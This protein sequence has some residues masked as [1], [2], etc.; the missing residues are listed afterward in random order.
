[1]LQKLYEWISDQEIEA[2]HGPNNFKNYMKC[3]GLGALNGLLEFFMGFGIFMYVLL[4]V[5]GIKSKL[6]KN[7]IQKD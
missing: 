3:F 4:L 1:M 6:G 5:L 7:A 2:V